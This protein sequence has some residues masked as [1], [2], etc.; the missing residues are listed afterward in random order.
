MLN[1][2][3][4]RPPWKLLGLRSQ[5]PLFVH[6]RDSNETPLDVETRLGRVPS[7]SVGLTRMLERCFRRDFTSR[8]YA[9]DLAEDAWLHEEPPT[10]NYNI[11]S[12]IQ[13][14][15]DILGKRAAD[16]LGARA[17]AWV[18]RRVG[19]G[20][21]QRAERAEQEADAFAPSAPGPANIHEVLVQGGN[22]TSCLAGKGAERL[23]L[24][25]HPGCHGTD[26]QEP[27]PGSYQPH[28]ARTLRTRARL[29]HRNC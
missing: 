15:E 29:G 14:L 17:L 27:K 4:A 13:G 2:A 11:G 7:L 5:F 24:F 6:I 22:T 12:T 3:T 25:A 23:P 19:E 1:M 16:A 18:D 20:A 10:P 21:A 8:P 26:L 28:A 9:H